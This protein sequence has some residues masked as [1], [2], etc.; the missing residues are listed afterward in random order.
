MTEQDQK[1]NEAQFMIQRIYM[2][3]TEYLAQMSSILSSL[4][5]I[6]YVIVTMINTFNAQQSIMKRIIKFRENIHYK[7]R[8]SLNY[9]REK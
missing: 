6:L 2:K 8:D 4:L 3:F 7:K 1:A 5:L 9:L